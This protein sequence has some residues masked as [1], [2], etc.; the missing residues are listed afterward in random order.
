M[1]GMTGADRSYHW[2]GGMPPFSEREIN[3]DFEAG[4][5]Q[6][7]ALADVVKENET[8]DANILK[9]MPYG[10]NQSEANKPTLEFPLMHIRS[11][12]GPEEGEG[13]ATKKLLENLANLLPKDVKEK[14]SQEMKRP[15]TQREPAYAAL[16]K[17]LSYTAAALTLLNQTARTFEGESTA[18]RYAKQNLEFTG[19]AL[20]ALIKEGK[21]LLQEGYAI[22]KQ[23]GPNHPHFDTL[24]KHLKN[25]ANALKLLKRISDE[26][27]KKKQKDQEEE[28][29]EE[30]EKKKSQKE[31]Q[32]KDPVELL[33][34]HV[35]L[36]SK[37]YDE[38][39][40]GGS[41]L[42]IGPL[43]QA[44][45]CIGR[46]Q[47]LNNGLRSILF[48]LL[49]YNIGI[50]DN[51]S[52]SSP[53]GEGTSRVVSQMTG[54][55]R[56]MCL[57]DIEPKAKEFFPYLSKA[58][59]IFC[60]TGSLYLITTH[61]HH[62]ILGESIVEDEEEYLNE[63]EETLVNTYTLWNLI[64]MFLRLNIIQKFI[65]Q[66]FFDPKYGITNSL[67]IVTET[68]ELT[69]ISII[70]RAIRQ[71]DEDA[72]YILLNGL[73]PALI[74]R[75]ETLEDVIDRMDTETIRSLGWGNE[76]RKSFAVELTNCRIAL[77]NEQYDQWY[78]HWDQVTIALGMDG[79][80]IEL[81]MRKFFDH[82]RLLKSLFT[83]DIED[84][85][86]A[87]TGIVQI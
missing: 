6:N 73:A 39:Y 72:S 41:L 60:V 54:I 59:V 24:L 82:A 19:Q 21:E 70:I 44:I 66:D 3:V 84:F 78:S 37:H 25:A 75:T 13:E 22:L 53:I 67:N 26:E 28:E 79:D 51:F 4:A 71:I 27:R 87:V 76:Q 30:K 9:G 57:S 12:T 47:S 23:L 61:A 17:S 36:Y 85:S 29:E 81:E 16:A 64:L 7:K 2:G 77:Q 58:F 10:R 5:L 32:K 38:S 42:Y 14:L 20:Q 49:F 34:E 63:S 52:A 55:M 11:R 48:G 68:I 80:S 86:N 40:T 56:E 65:P 62:K 69:T 45:Y 83:E 8:I 33:L 15:E 74:Q 1:S 46:T 35:E 31:N 50:E 43:L 18:I